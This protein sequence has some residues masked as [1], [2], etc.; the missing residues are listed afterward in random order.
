MDS[1]RSP[2]TRTC[3][4]R[5]SIP[6]DPTEWRRG[7]PNRWIEAATPLGLEEATDGDVAD[8]EGE[9]TGRRSL[10]QG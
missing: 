9:G 1:L 3:G 8:L 6:P 7:H 4:D 2:A 10:A 5:S